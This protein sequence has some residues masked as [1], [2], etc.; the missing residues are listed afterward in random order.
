MISGQ[1]GYEARESQRD[2]PLHPMSEFLRSTDVPDLGLD[3]P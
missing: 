1:V 3:E 2:A